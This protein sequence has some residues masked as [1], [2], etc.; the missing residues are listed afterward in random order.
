MSSQNNSGDVREAVGVFD[1]ADALQEAIDE[2][3]SSGFDRADLSLMTSEH[4]VEDKLGHRYQKVSELEDDSQT[5]RASYIAPESIGEAQGALVGGLFYIGAIGAAGLIFASGGS[6]AAAILAATAA[7]GA[8]GLLG[9]VLGK[10]IGDRHA[11]T[12]QEQIDRGGLLLWV[13][14]WDEDHE[15]RAVDILTKHSGHDVHVHGVRGG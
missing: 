5:P 15:K 2:L 6:M 14:T 7:G 4:V 11:Q 12:L 3:Q 13:R 9:A 1:T 8:G 10:L